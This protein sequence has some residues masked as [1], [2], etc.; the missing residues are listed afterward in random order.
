M[1]YEN[2]PATK[3]LAVH[4]ACCSK[5]L[6][7]SISVETGVGPDCRKM[8]RFDEAQGPADFEAAIKMAGSLVQLEDWSVWNGNARKA[9]NVLVHRIAVDQNGPH[10]AFLAQAIKLLGYEKLGERILHRVAKIRIEI[11]PD[12]LTY[13]VKAPYK[14]EAV[15]K[16]RAIPGRIWVKERRV[17]MVPVKE[18]RALWSVLCGTYAGEIAM[19]PKGPFVIGG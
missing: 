11:S 8:H 16:W 18:K 9:C 14:E 12:G 19:G 3:M 6:V 17:T 7:D 13:E 10:V 15:P 1:S 2:A 4:C 5:A